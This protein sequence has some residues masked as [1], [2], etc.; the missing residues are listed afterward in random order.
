VKDRR[1]ETSFPLGVTINPENEGVYVVDFG[2]SRI[3]I[4]SVEEEFIGK[5][6]PRVSVEKQLPSGIAI[7]SMN[8]VPSGI[9]GLERM[10]TS[11]NTCGSHWN[12]QV[13]QAGKEPFSAGLIKAEF[14]DQLQSHPMAC[15]HPGAG[16]FCPACLTSHAP[17]L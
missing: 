13:R 11:S 17:E 8:N 10:N 6:G 7:D 15:R 5:W 3:Q 2:N 9:C 12:I 1:R 4:F 16:D 14:V